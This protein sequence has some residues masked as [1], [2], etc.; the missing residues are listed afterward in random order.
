RGQTVPAFEKAAF[1][2]KPNQLS[3]LITTEYGFHVIQVLAHQEAQTQSFDE[4]KPQLLAEARRQIGDD[5]MQKAVSEARDEIARNPSQAENI[6]KKYGLKFF[7]ADQV[8]SGAVLPD[9]NS[10]PELSNAVFASAKG[11]VTP[12]IPLDNVGKAAFASVTTIFPPR[13]ANFD[14][15]QK[16]VIDRYTTEQATELMQAAAKQAAE[17]AK[18][19]QSLEAVAKE[20]GGEVKSAQPFTIMGAAEGIGPAKTLEAAFAAKTKVGDAFGPVTQANS[21][22]VCKVTQ[23]T[24][25][26]MSKFAESREDMIQTVKQRKAQV[27]QG[28]F[29][30]SVVAELEKQGVIKLNTPAINRLVASYKS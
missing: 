17:K 7:K 2:L 23:K 3:D 24:P 12:V 11:E 6:A 19:G 15:V 5:N 29:A 8:A 1:S 21:A 16:D 4:V 30:D 20:F 25:A 9:V 28:L 13:Q 26:D 14:E 10:Q 22:F 18:N 27:Q